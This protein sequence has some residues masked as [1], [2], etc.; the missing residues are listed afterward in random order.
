M[1]L[2]GGSLFKVCLCL[3]CIYVE[4]ASIFTV[5]LC[6]RMFKEYVCLRMFKV[7]VCLRCIYFYGGSLFEVYLCVRRI[8]SNPTMKQKDQKLTLRLFSSKQ[9]EV[10][11]LTAGVCRR[12]CVKVRLSEFMHKMYLCL[13]RIYV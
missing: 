11:R 13:R 7:Y 9:R 4:G 1:Y 10:T 6:L 5:D 8:S 2:C 3:R 12:M